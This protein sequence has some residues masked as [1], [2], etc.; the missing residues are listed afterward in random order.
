[1]TACHLCGDDLSRG[2]VVCEV[3][4]HGEPQTSIACATCGLVQA[5]PLPSDAELAAY[6]AGPY[7][8]LYAPLPFGGLAPGTPE[9][10]AALVAN[11]EAYAAGIVARLG[12]TADSRVLEVGCGEGRLAAALAKRCDAVA[13]EAD[14]AMAEAAAARGATVM[15]AASL[16]QYANLSPP[17]VTPWGQE[18]EAVRNDAIVCCHVLEHVADP[19]AALAQMRSLL[20]PG[21]R[22]WLEVPS[23]EAPYGDLAWF[24]QRPHLWNF[25]PVTLAL[26]LERAGLDD[27]R[28]NASGHVLYAQGTHGAAAPRT[29][30]EAAAVYP[31]PTPGDVV[32][33]RL[34]AYQAAR[35]GNAGLTLERWLSGTPAAALDED[36]LRAD[37]VRVAEAVMVATNGIGQAARDLDVESRATEDDWHA[38][39]WLLG[40]R[41][42]RASAMQRAAGVL[43]ALA[44]SIVVRSAG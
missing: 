26:L 21:G 37:F 35:D 12:L 20:A 8:A 9:Y 38:D 11:S 10:E 5:T 2:V 22:V 36:A 3:A 6:Y 15:A 32:A 44:N 23:V 27:V 16:A 40:Y 1:M 29:Y 31:A 30:A 28:V 33:A 17:A 39:P 24:F 41:D 19:L 14:P 18:M 43:S 13:I 4:R 34:R 42:G 25:A 7:R